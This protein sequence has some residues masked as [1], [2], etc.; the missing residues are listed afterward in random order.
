MERK[1]SVEREGEKKQ[2]EGTGKLCQTGFVG[3]TAIGHT[4]STLSMQVRR[5]CK[6]RGASYPEDQSRIRSRT[7]E[8]PI[9]ARRLP[10]FL[11]DTQNVFHAAVAVW[12]VLTFWLQNA[13]RKNVT[14]R[15]MNG[16][17]LEAVKKMRN[18]KSSQKTKEKLEKSIFES[19]REKAAATTMIQR[20]N[21]YSNPV[22]SSGSI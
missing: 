7:C 8:W 12:F 22:V 15:K 13:K 14:H 1:L 10:G 16:I 17:Y 5:E 9:L 2:P 6:R 20:H 4:I 3:K 19:C 11:D 18:V 21:Y